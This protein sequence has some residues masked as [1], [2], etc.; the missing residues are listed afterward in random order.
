MDVWMLDEVSV[1]GG[2]IPNSFPLLCFLSLDVSDIVP[3]FI[4]VSRISS[5]FEL[6]GWSLFNSCVGLAFSFTDLALSVIFIDCA[7]SISIVVTPTK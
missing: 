7:F 3:T 5:A 1:S 6:H 4:R 2:G